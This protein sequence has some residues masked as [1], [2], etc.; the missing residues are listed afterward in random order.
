MIV[1]ETNVLIYC[2]LIRPQFVEKEI[3]RCL[4]TIVIP[5][6]SGEH[7]FTHIYFVPV[8]KSYIKHIRLE[9]RDQ[10]GEPFALST[11]K[12]PIKF[13]LHFRRIPTW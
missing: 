10:A 6:L 3:I 12:V 5:L 9:V 1:G 13:V 8:E 7:Y 2:D 4:R 11:D